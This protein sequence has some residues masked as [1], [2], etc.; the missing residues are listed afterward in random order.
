LRSEH[1]LKISQFH[2]A[3]ILVVKT[4][5][6]LDVDQVTLVCYFASIAILGL[7]EALQFLTLILRG[8]TVAADHVLKEFFL[9]HNEDSVVVKEN[10]IGI[11][12][13]TIH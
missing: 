7:C 2:V 12:W 8:L 9:G 6:L 1:I 4:V 5:V 3:Q 11:Y 13:T 10:A